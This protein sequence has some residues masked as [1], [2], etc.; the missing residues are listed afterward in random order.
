MHNSY[1][2]KRNTPSVF[3]TC[4][5]ARASIGDSLMAR[6]GSPNPTH[7]LVGR[8]PLTQQQTLIRSCA[9][10]F[11]WFHS[12]QSHGPHHRFDPPHPTLVPHR[13]ILLFPPAKPIEDCAWTIINRLISCRVA[14]LIDQ[15]DAIISY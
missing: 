7:R 2:H 14:R 3:A 6:I 10:N 8:S 15:E 5:N 4:F 13:C 11:L 9:S 1:L 12:V